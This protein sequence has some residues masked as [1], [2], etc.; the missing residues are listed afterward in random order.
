VSYRDYSNFRVRTNFVWL[1]PR[2]FQLH[3][4]ASRLLA[5]VMR[6][7]V[8]LLLATP[9]REHRD[10]SVPKEAGKRSRDSASGV[11]KSSK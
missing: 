5:N 3:L 2:T 1:H 8:L 4:R 9:L 10:D 7:I 11:D 6:T